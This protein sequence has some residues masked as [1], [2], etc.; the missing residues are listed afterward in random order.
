MKSELEVASSEDFRE[1]SKVMSQ[2]NEKSI[3]TIHKDFDKVIA[4]KEEEISHLRDHNQKLLLQIKAKD[5]V[6]CS[7]KLEEKIQALQQKLLGKDKENF[8]PKKVNQELEEQIEKLKE[9]KQSEDERFEK[10][11][12]NNN[13]LENKLVQIQKK[14]STLSRTLI[15]VEEE[16]TNTNLVPI[17]VQK[18][19]NPT[20]K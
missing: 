12:N 15:P 13:L 4:S 7:Q 2:G 17:T 11:H 18:E 9:D 5:K 16:E 6:Q 8:A 10:I 20:K 14:A 1:I 3:Q 19:V